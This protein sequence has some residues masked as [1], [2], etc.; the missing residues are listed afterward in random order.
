[1]FF[2]NYI[3]MYLRSPSEE[4]RNIHSSLGWGSPST[5][6]LSALPTS[7]LP[8]V[9]STLTPSP[10]TRFAAGGPKSSDAIINQNNL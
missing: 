3:S 10:H 9:T 2:R 5:T 6:S 1:M 8:P 7:P 4:E